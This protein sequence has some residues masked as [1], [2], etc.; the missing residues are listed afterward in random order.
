MM[1][2]DSADELRAAVPEQF[3]GD[4]VEA[5]R[6]MW[7][8]ALLENNARRFAIDMSDLRECDPAGFALLHKMHVH[9]V[10]IVAATPLSLA[11]LR[12]ISGPFKQ[13]KRH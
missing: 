2:W 11:F 10:H 5:L 12:E 13:T 6:S 7:E 3:A 8:T 9:G 4:L 1:I